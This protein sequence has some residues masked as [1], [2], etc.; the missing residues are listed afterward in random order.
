MIQRA[1]FSVLALILCCVY[2]VRG[3]EVFVI[4]REEFNNAPYNGYQFGRFDIDTPNTS[5]GTGNYV[6]SFVPI[7]TQ[8]TNNMQNLA[9][10]PTNSTMYLV[11]DDNTTIEYRSITATGTMSGNL[12][13]TPA[14]GGLSFDNVGNLYGV[15]GEFQASMI[16]LNATT[17]A[18]ITASVT[19]S[20]IYSSFAGNMAWLGG[21]Y[22]FANENDYNLVTIGTNG[23]VTTKGAFSGTGYDNNKAHAL[24]RKD[25]QLYMLNG[26]NLYTVNVTNGAL[27]KLGSISGVGGDAPSNGFAGA[28]VPEPS[29][30]VMALMAFVVAVAIRF[31]PGRRIRFA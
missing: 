5:G 28:V 6:Y 17:G 26:L 25:S 30:I 12:G 22:Y 9:W 19:S 23:A 11:Y 14:R 7:G 20:T 24:F 27:T 29:A 18:Q 2:P 8:S 4:A 31:R 10:N 15:D 13:V 3:V 1:T 21:Q 16:Q